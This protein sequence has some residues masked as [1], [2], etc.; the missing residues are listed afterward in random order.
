MAGQWTNEE[1]IEEQTRKINLT[2]RSDNEEERVAGKWTIEERIEDKTRKLNITDN[3]E[4][5]EATT[6]KKQ[7]RG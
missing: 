3:K 2:G 1:R 4:T 5:A 7:S 6:K